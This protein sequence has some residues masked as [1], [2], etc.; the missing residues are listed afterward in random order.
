MTDASFT[1]KPEPY[2][3]CKLAN[4][5]VDVFIRI[6]DHEEITDDG[7]T[8]YVYKCNEF[9]V[10]GT[11][12]REDMVKENPEKYLTYV[13][14]KKEEISELERIQALEAA[15]LDLMGVTYE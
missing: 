10:C 15:V 3:Y 6:F 5:T 12:V 13:S 11:D 4:G 14:N 2:S 9:N 7:N 8:M 1:T